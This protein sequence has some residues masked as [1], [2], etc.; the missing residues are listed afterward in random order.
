MCWRSKPAWAAL[1]AARAANEGAEDM[2]PSAASLM[3]REVWSIGPDEPL[4][5]I[6][7]QMVARNL[8]WVPVAEPDGGVLG[9]I[10]AWDLLRFH[11]DQKGPGT[12]A[13]QLCT[14]RP[15]SVHPDAS[16]DEV[17]RLMLEA[18]VHHVIVAA[19]DGALLGVLSSSDLL[20]AWVS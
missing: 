10:S 5:S 7:K 16:A 15:V 19:E 2:S 8:R 20:R 11:A 13:W 14:Y 3:Q 18:K 4:E 1:R 9:V 17:A 12:C 6:E